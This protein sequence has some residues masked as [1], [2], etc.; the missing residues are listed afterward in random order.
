MSNRPTGAKKKWLLYGPS[1]FT[2]ECKLLKEYTVNYAAQRPHNE[3][4]SRSS[5]NKK[6]GKT[7]KFGGATE[8]VKNMV[9]HDALIP[10][11]KKGGIRQKS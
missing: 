6:R 11:K 9:A 8:E 3:K 2:E 7:V 10:R 5:G 4:E 1:H